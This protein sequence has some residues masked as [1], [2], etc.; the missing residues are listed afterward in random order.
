MTAKS[1]ML[2]EWV[3]KRCAKPL[4]FRE[5]LELIGPE[6]AGA[7]LGSYTEQGAKRWFHRH[8]SQLGGHTPYELLMTTKQRVRHLP[9][10]MSNGAVDTVKKLAIQLLL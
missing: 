10:W 5:A 2:G 8:R 9:D 3:C 7:L 1:Y 6:A 4:S